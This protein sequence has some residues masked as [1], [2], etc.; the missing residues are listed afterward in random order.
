MDRSTFTA[1]MISVLLGAFAQ[2]ILK[3]G[4]SAPATVN[5]LSKGT[6][7][8]FVQS[9]ASS[10]LVWIGLACYGGAALVWLI[11]LARVEVSLAY[12]LVGLGFVVTMILGGTLL[13]AAGVALISRG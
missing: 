12:P 4:M 10:P 13:I 1:V 9:T 3:A 8:S 5:A 11:V 7:W 6:T 2:I